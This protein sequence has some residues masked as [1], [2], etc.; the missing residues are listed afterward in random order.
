MNYEELIR[1]PGKPISS[2]SDMFEIFGYTDIQNPIYSFDLMNDS[3]FKYLKEMIDAN[4]Q[5]IPKHYN[6]NIIRLRDYRLG[7]L[8]NEFR[9]FCESA[10]HCYEDAWKEYRAEYN[11]S[12][13]EDFYHFWCLYDTITIDIVFPKYA[14][15]ID[16]ISM[17][18][19]DMEYSKVT[20]I[21]GIYKYKI[22]KPIMTSDPRFL[23]PNTDVEYQDHK[24]D[25][26][27]GAIANELDEELREY[28]PTWL[29]RVEALHNELTYTEPEK[30]ESEAQFIKRTKTY[31]RRRIKN[32]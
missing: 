27:L 4:K 12:M 21:D 11:P 23:Y 26:V 16:P 24:P 22:P 32:A 20:C 29:I 19:I 8:I 15:L 17:N 28:F 10:L 5:N 18:W 2:G 31:I 14:D 25:Y 3:K 7:S 6:A 30:D 1:D 9:T 13:P